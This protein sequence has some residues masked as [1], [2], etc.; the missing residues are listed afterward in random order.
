MGQLFLPKFL[1]LS[2]VSL[3]SH[4]P[5]LSVHLF[6]TLVFCE[7][8][9]H[10]DLELVFHPLLFGKSL[11]LK[12]DLVVLCFLQL[13]LLSKLLVFFFL[14][15]N[16][17]LLFLLLHLQ[18][19]SKSFYVLGFLSTLSLLLSK[20]VKDGISLGFHLGL[21]SLEFVASLLLLILELFDHLVFI[22]FEL[23][24]SF[25]QSILFVDR[26]N[27]VLLGLLL[28]ELSYAHHLVVLL[29]H[30]V[31]DLVDLTS[32]FQV[33]LLGLVTETLTILHLVLN[34]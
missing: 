1:D 7:F 29:N 12:S 20:S 10:L 30:L 28:L 13:H 3:L 32:F 9:C 8:L 18:F 21:H 23:S 25:E 33:L 6:Q 4:S 26:K 27:H 34:L 2:L 24:L 19:V 14:F 15:L 16:A 11:G 5:L 17:S 22:L 31:D